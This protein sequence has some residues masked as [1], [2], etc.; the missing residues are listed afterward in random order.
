MS[1]IIDN[2][3]GSNYLNKR[4]VS[5]PEFISALGLIALSMAILHET[6]FYM[7]LGLSM[8]KVPISIQDV[9]ASSLSWLPISLFGTI[10]ATI[11]SIF[12]NKISNK[13]SRPTATMLISFAG[14][15]I[16]FIFV[17]LDSSMPAV[18]MRSRLIGAAI[19]SPIV[20]LIT[21]VLVSHEKK[22]VVSTIFGAPQLFLIVIIGLSFNSSFGGFRSGY[23]IDVNQYQDT[24]NFIGDNKVDNVHIIRNYSGGLLVID[25]DHNVTFYR[26]DVVS[27]IKTFI[28][29]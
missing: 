29:P 9:L 22:S 4:Q 19:I 16:L 25:R 3:I 17:L 26:Q 18:D 21:F 28:G 24:V 6:F 13:Y 2:G 15:F 20:I 5:I 14:I 11:F 23:F 7:G 1:N 27:H 10:F 8:N 12:A